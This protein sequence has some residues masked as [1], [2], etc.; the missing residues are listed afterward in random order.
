M[1]KEVAES[2]SGGFVGHLDELG[3]GLLPAALLEELQAEELGVG[4]GQVDDVLLHV[5]PEVEQRLPEAVE[6]PAVEGA[7]VVVT[8]TL[9]KKRA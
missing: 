5:A 4:L 3:G 8:G 2:E 7:G 6:P 1:S 9:S